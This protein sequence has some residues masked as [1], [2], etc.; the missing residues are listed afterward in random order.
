MKK[1]MVVMVILLGLIMVFSDVGISYFLLTKIA[2]INVDKAIEGTIITNGLTII[3]LA[4]T[5]WLGITIYNAIG[6]SEIDELKTTL[7][8][9]SPL[10]EQV[11]EYTKQQ[12]VNQMYRTEDVSCDYMAKLFEKNNEIPI[13]RYADLLVI[14]ILLQRTYEAKNEKMKVQKLQW[15][16]T[17]IEKINR[18]RGK[19]NLRCKLEDSYLNYREADFWFH[20]GACCQ[21]GN[22]VRNYQKAKELFIKTIEDFKISLT[23]SKEVVVKKASEDIRISVYFAN[24][25]AQCLINMIDN[26]MTNEESESLKTEAKKYYEYAV[27]YSKYC[28]EREVYY[29]NYGCF[30]ENTAKNM[31]D[32]EKAYK[33][34]KKAFSV[35]EKA[36]KV[37]AV[38]LSNLNKR[39]RTLLGIE[40]RTPQKNRQVPIW[41]MSFDEMDNCEKI[42]QL[43]AEMKFFIEMAIHNFPNEPYW[44]AYSIYR[45]LY[46]ACLENDNNVFDWIKSVHSMKKDVIKMDMLEGEKALCLVAKAEVEDIEEYCRKKERNNA[47]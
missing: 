17:G 32:M 29:R 38:L 43:I 19:Y 22:R 31:E 14:D 42:E 45:K 18:Y 33:Q 34:Y 36:Q 4:I 39:I 12:F 30:L 15:A 2:S 47:K 9:Y 1:I 21:D 6:K 37:Y 27:E 40:M 28:G 16:H 8:K 23:M 3:S 20:I 26:N 13:E 25:I 44:Y 5:V 10:S 41:N 11:R 24:A 35:D 7:E 46:K